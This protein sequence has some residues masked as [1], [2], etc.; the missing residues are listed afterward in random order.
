MNVVL[1][2]W[3]YLSAG[4][5]VNNCVSLLNV[6]ALQIISINIIYCLGHRPVSLGFSS[7]YTIGLRLIVNVSERL[8]CSITKDWPL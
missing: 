3:G 8:Y 4:F 5:H 1:S 2:L 7:F 6:V